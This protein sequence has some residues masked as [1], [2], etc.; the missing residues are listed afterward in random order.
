MS[1]KPVLYSYFRSS[2]SWRVRIALAMKGIDYEYKAV[3]L[4][5]NEQSDEDYKKQC[6]PQG[7]VPSFEINGHKMSQSL[8]ILEYLDEVYPDNPLLPKDCPMKRADVRRLSLLI[9]ADIQPVQNLRV[10][11]KV[12]ELNS[13]K[14]EWG[15][16]AID[17]GFVALERSLESTHG[18]Y[19]YGDQVTMVDLCLVPQV[20]NANRFKVDMSK[21]PIITKIHEELVKL[22][23][24]E[25]A[26][27]TKQPD[28]PEDLK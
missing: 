11:K 12:V 24:F 14:M 16:W 9:A 4:L 18:K 22:P 7:S 3:N 28:C 6:N 15:K 19:C 26:H 5:K 10:L 20:Y 17:C 2:C 21:F 13:D 23:A 25:A 8:S 27:P 1:D